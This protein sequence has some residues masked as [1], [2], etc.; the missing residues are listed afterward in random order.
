MALRASCVASRY[1]DSAW[2]TALC[3][4][5]CSMPRFTTSDSYTVK[6]EDAAEI[7]AI[8]P[9]ASTTRREMERE[10]IIEPP[11]ARAR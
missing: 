3:A 7:D 5:V 6:A 9:N 11:S 2:L 4:N 10:L 1:F 8:S